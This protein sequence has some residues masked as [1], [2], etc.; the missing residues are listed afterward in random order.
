MRKPTIAAMELRRGQ[1]HRSEERIAR[2]DAKRAKRQT[3]MAKDVQDAVSRLCSVYGVTL[4]ILRSPTRVANI[5]EARHLLF[6]FLR[7][8]C[9]YSVN[10]VARYLRRDNSTVI[11]CTLSITDRM[12]YEPSFRRHA[13][14]LSAFMATGIVNDDTEGVEQMGHA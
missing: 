12:V 5:V 6:W 10:D 11:K 7:H 1:N 13:F 2:R 4:D 3:D 9:G 14:E 8:H